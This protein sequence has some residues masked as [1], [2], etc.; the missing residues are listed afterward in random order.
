MPKSDSGTMK[1]RVHDQEEKEKF[2]AIV[3]GQS[4]CDRKR[5]YSR[6]QRSRLICLA[7][8]QFS[9]C[10]VTPV[11][12]NWTLVHLQTLYRSSDRDKFVNHRTLSGRGIIT[13]EREQ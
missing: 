11:Y 13:I 3:D 8:M 7:C 1:V 2:V 9:C 5:Y 4:C 12:V 6:P 10:A